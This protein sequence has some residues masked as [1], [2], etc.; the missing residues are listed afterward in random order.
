M[1][2]AN[3]SL[4]SSGQSG[5]G[6]VKMGLASIGALAEKEVIPEVSNELAFDGRL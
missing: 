1:T 4:S 5:A 6:V 2:L 3:Q